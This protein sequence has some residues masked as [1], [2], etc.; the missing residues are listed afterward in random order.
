MKRRLFTL[1]SATSLVLCL[2]VVALWV[3]S[4]WAADDLT[5]G[6]SH[7]VRWISTARGR[8]A[9]IRLKYLATLPAERQGWHYKVSDPGEVA[10]NVSAVAA[11]T[12][13]GL[14]FWRVRVTS[15]AH[16]DLQVFVAVLPLWLPFAVIAVMPLRWFQTMLLRRQSGLGI[17]PSCGY[18]LRA[19]PNRCPECGTPAAKGESS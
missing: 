10:A 11:S 8:F 2:A 5:V 6:N 3:R 15:E 1:A 18:D 7:S 12:A 19:T 4:Y 17:C 16:S 14:D 13:G 9:V